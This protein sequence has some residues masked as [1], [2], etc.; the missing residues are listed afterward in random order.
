MPLDPDPVLSRHGSDATLDQQQHERP[1][2][3]QG[4]SRP[5]RR[6]LLAAG[7]AWTIPT[8]VLATASPALAVSVKCDPGCPAIAFGSN[9]PGNGWTQT[10]RGTFDSDAPLR[11]DPAYK[12]ARGTNQCTQQYGGEDSGTLSSAVVAD[13]N[14]TAA[15]AVI[16]YEHPVCLTAGRRYTFSFS[17]NTYANNR[18]GQTMT[19]TLRSATDAELATADPVVTTA[20]DPDDPSPNK[21]GTRSLAF[22]A[23]SSQIATFRYAWTFATT[24]VGYTD[25]CDYQANDIAVT[26]PT[27]S[28]TNP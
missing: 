27:I 10:K 13:G 22:V 8:A 26:A 17:W 23:T 3:A 11:Y 5:R 21:R 6:A 14:P 2:G 12:P 16:T 24:P 15:G 19:A 25:Y 28:C 4:P 7:T 18:R 20:P 1:A 9:V